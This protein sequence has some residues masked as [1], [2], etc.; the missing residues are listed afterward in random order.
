MAGLG[1]APVG[2]L[3]GIDLVD[4]MV[5]ADALA[6]RNVTHLA[7]NIPPADDRDCLRQAQQTLPLTVYPGFIRVWAD[8]HHPDVQALSKSRAVMVI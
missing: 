2:G 3:D 4:K 8:R 5:S 7:S 6:R 1:T